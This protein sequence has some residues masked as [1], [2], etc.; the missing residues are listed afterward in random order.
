MAVSITHI[1]TACALIN[2]NG[3]HILTDP[4]LDPAGGWYHHGFGSL[5]KK[6]QGP[7]IVAEKLPPIDLVLLSHHQHKDN[8]DRKGKALTANVHLVLSTPQ[9]ARELL[10]AKGLN[11][12]ETISIPTPLVPNLRITATPCQHHPWWLPE[13]FSGNVIGFM[14]E[15]DSQQSADRGGIY[16]SGDTVY[17]SGIDEIAKRFKI[18]VGIFHVG[19]A[20]FRY[21]SG[22]GQYTMNSNHL[23]KAVRVLK[24]NT[25]VPIHTKG[26][27]H[28]KE[29]ETTLK[30]TL[31]Q[32][33]EVFS[34][35]VFLKSGI[36]EQLR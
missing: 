4:T 11:N 3:Y 34:K 2:I 27:S 28:F 13:F 18:D 36:E 26:W 25:I 1:D 16:I 6:T 35:T 21:L 24:P 23:L 12:W 15:F 33:P 7:A 20:Q 5:S 19:S 22:F 32:Y 9:A 8:F 10:N 30:D 14:I 31:Q 17:F 29:T